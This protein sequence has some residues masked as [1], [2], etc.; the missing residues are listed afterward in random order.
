MTGF[1]R[2]W[3]R[4]SL[5]AALG[6]LALVVP[7]AAEA[8]RPGPELAS[9][10]RAAA[11]KLT[12]ADVPHVVK[13]GKDHVIVDADGRQLLLRGI[14]AN[15][16]VEYP[17]YYQETVPLK[18]ADFG[19][20]AALG[21]T[22]LRLPISWS[23]LEPQPGQYSSAYVS[24]IRTVV[25]RAE[26]A[27]LDVLVDMHQDRYNRNL[28]P[29]DEA[30]G[31]PDWATITNDQPCQ[32][33]QLTSPCSAAAYDAFWQNQTVEGKPLQT[34]YRDA[35][36][37]VSRVFRS[38]RRLLGYELMNEPTPGSMGSP[39]WERKQLWPF[40]RRMITALRHDGEPHMIWFGPSVLRDALD[41]DPGNPKRFS[42]D[43]DLVYAPHI[44]TGTFNG[45]GADQ[46][47]ASYAA[48]QK[49]ARSYG[50][51]LVDAEWGGGSDATAES[52]RA[53]NLQLQ[54]R[55]RIGSAFWMW[56]QAPG[57]Y[58]W[59]TVE[60][61]GSL[62]TDSM[63]AQMLSQPHVEAVPGQ[64]VRTSYADG[65]LTVRVRG[66]GGVVSLWSGTVVRS[67]ATTL[68]DRPLVAATVDGRHT[69]GTRTAHAFVAGTTSLLGYRVDVR[70]PAGHHTVVLQ[71]P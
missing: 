43:G 38:D 55:Y 47:R 52:L 54:D 28:R 60:A 18:K 7:T 26:S 51:A 68:V 70:V 23:R 71:A 37:Q 14:N 32:V 22:F 41:A 15:A 1:A 56:K 63:R 11:T 6:A 12:R 5:L 29:G 20:M 44:Y 35:L 4:P 59:Q 9:A 48:A 27:G 69:T 53:E 25:R 50:A 39:T 19:E 2:R 13:Q 10:P 33:S 49:E 17:S 67:G 64:L 58:N 36:L 40:E 62:R 66:R 21:F 16:L 61:D 46:L 42:G 45:G 34:W 24:R 65:V 31:A 57:F 8:V 3:S 30:D